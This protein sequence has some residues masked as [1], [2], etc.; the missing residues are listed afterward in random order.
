MQAT[1]S[2]MHK[3]AE[4]IAQLLLSCPTSA[5]LPAGTLS[6]GDHVALMFNPGL[7]LIAGF[8]GCLYAGCI[9][10]PVRPIPAHAGSATTVTVKMMVNVSK[11]VA[12][13]TNGAI[14]R[15]LKSKEVSSALGPQDGDWPA[16]IDIEESPRKK[17]PITYRPP[18]SEM[19]AYVDF[20]VSTSGTLMGIK[21]TSVVLGTFEHQDL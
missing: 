2:Q 20:S 17:H 4:R 5:G 1:C 15:I 14:A 13:L 21:V 3:K 7:D 12:I 19:L 6:T 8:Y 10:V 11:A 18:T 9:P 16:I